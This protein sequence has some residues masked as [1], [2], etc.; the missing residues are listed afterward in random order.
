VTQLKFLNKI[1][2]QIKKILR[3]FDVI[4]IYISYLTFPSYTY[5]FST[6]KLYPSKKDRWTKNKF[7]PFIILNK[8][9]KNFKKVNLIVKGSSFD[10]NRLKNFKDPTFLTGFTNTLRIKN[11]NIF[12]QHEHGDF[13]Y[14]GMN[15]H[16]KLFQ[17]KNL[18]YITANPFLALELH[19]NDKILF[20]KVLRKESDS[21]RYFW[22][23]YE[24][25]KKKLKIF[26]KFKSIK[27][28]KIVENIYKNYDTE[29]KLWAPSGSTVPAIYYLLSVSKKINVYG[30]DF[31]FDKKVNNHNFFSFLKNIYKFQHDTKRSWNHIESCLMNLYFAY[32][33][34]KRKEIS[35]KGNLSGLKSQKRFIRKFE[36][37]IFKC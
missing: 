6:R 29:Q 27:K 13:R 22:P 4:M 3:I 2:F 16:L 9:K 26:N 20:M 35:L 21:K 8:G 23:G 32:I 34:E 19:K 31:Y 36:K 25:I 33:L 18:R 30:W 11:N 10:L 17:K 7:N 1:K 28:V 37:V 14:K 5:F 15:K 12:Y 24:K